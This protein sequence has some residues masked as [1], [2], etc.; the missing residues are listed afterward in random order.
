[1]CFTPILGEV[2]VVKKRKK[3][4]KKLR[5]KVT[6]ALHRGADGPAQ[7]RVGARIHDRRV[8]LLAS[9]SLSLHFSKLGAVLLLLL[10]L[11][12]FVCRRLAWGAFS[13]KGSGR[14]GDLASPKCWK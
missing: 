12:S 6:V 4:R 1:M 3:E 14:N 11:L 2:H 9:A 8:S 5:K 7:L 10:L 13:P